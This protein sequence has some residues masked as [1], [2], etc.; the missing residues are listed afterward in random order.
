MI[1]S[2]SQRMPASRASAAAL[3]ALERYKKK[4][5]RLRRAHGSLSCAGNSASACDCGQIEELI[6]YLQN[7]VE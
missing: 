1:H 2:S 4:D 3:A 6:P 5:Y 7:A